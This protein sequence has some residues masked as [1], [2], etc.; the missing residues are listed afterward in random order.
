[1]CLVDELPERGDLADLLDRE[2]LIL[3]V[4]V[5]GQAGGVVAA[6]FEA[7]EACGAQTGQLGALARGAAGKSDLP[8]MRVL[9][10]YFLSFSTR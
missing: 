3:L 6:V 8:L 4:A 1:V 2:H 5:Y 7:G 10:M 9:R